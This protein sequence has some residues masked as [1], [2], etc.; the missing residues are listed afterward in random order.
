[1]NNVCDVTSIGDD[2]FQLTST[3][4]VMDGTTGPIGRQLLTQELKAHPPTRWVMWLFLGLKS[5]RWILS[6][7]DWDGESCHAMACCHKGYTH[8]IHFMS[9]LQFDMVGPNRSSIDPV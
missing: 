2:A 5:D 1:M 9:M 4:R 7:V 8:H 3:Q 6:S